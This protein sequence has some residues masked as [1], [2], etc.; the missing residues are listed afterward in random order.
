MA[1]QS[2]TSSRASSSSIPAVGTSKVQ[3]KISHMEYVQK[4]TDYLVRGHQMYYAIE[5]LT[6]V[7]CPMRV[8]EKCRTEEIVKKYCSNQFLKAPVS[9]FMKKLSALRKE[10]VENA[11][12]RM[13]Q[14]KIT[15]DY[16]FKPDFIKMHEEKMAKKDQKANNQLFAS[17]LSNVQ[18]NPRP[19]VAR[20]DYSKYKIVKRTK[21]SESSSS[22]SSVF[23]SFVL[24]DSS[25]P[26]HFVNLLRPPHS[27]KT[28]HSFS[29]FSFVFEYRSLNF[30]ILVFVVIMA[31]QL[32]TSSRVSSSSIPAIRASKVQKKISPTEYVQKYTEYLVRGHQSSYA[33]DRLTGVICLLKIF[34]QCHTEE[35]V[36]K[37]CS[38]KTELNFPVAVFRKKLATL[39]QEE[40]AFAK[41]R[42]NEGKM[43]VDYTFKPELIQMH[44]KK[45]ATV[46]QKTTNELFANAFKRVAQK[47]AVSRPDT[48]SL[49]LS[50]GQ[51]QT[52]L[53][54]QD[55]RLRD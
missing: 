2:S 49:R 1:P 40:L 48:P 30:L 7:I 24:C 11:K 28:P 8:F 33:L 52:S 47:P 16:S 32:C 21:S 10:E 45:M 38:Q 15:V 44:E 46:N 37:Y 54:P 36:I 55:H 35:V 20:P 22:G 50:S 17:A 25:P 29:S 53:P 3:K 34:E 13:E 18:T 31:P 5:R 39:R 51:N 6:D 41:K 9:I 26:P 42:M 23:F 19:A 12:R 27:T 43:T 14:S 4:Y